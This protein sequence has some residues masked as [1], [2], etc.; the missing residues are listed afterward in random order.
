MLVLR[1]GV[2]VG[3]FATALYYTYKLKVSPE[4]SYSGLTYRAPDPASYLTMVG[5]VLLIAVA[6]PARLQR[7]SDFILW[8]FFVL[9]VAPSM[10]IPQY[11]QTLQPA[12]STITG[13]AVGAAFLF[14]LLLMKVLPARISGLR[15]KRIQNGVNFWF[16]LSVISLTTYAYM[17]ATTGLNL[18]FLSLSNVYDVRTEFAAATAGGALAYLVPLQANIINPIFFARGVYSGRLLFLAAGVAGQLVIYLSKGQ[19]STLFSV[20]L[21]F[22]IAMLFRYRPRP[23]GHVVLTAVTL[24]SGVALLLDR[25]TDSIFWTSLISRRMMIVPGALTA[26]YVA[27]FEDRPR[28][29]FATVLP[30]IENPYTNVRPVNIVGSEFVGNS[31]TAANVNLFGD[32]YLQFG[33]LGMFIEAGFLVILLI[34]ANEATRGLPMAVSA[35]IFTGPAIALVSASIF[36]A[37][38]TH[39]FLVGILICF[40][41]PSRNWGKQGRSVSRDAALTVAATR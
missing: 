19:K 5:A 22:G 34:L 21:M 18:R 8:T 7:V 14:A 3:L 27:V 26:A 11:A 35:I 38:V 9:G 13:F 37:A 12:Q 10:L 4:F 39:G 40:F 33:Y 1:R 6:M 25:I 17:M 16:A 2:A 24:A 36:T 15:P 20:V 29:N 32:G 23:S 30:G 28:L 31:S 41:A